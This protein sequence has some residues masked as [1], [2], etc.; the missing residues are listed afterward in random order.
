MVTAVLVFGD[1]HHPVRATVSLIFV[2]FVPGLAILRLIGLRDLEMTILL[3]IPLSLSLDAAMSAVLV[4]AGLSAWNLGLSILLSVTVGAV[5]LDVARPRVAAVRSPR[6]V[7][8]KLEDEVRQ[9]EVVRALLDGGSLADAA[10][11]ARVDVTTLQRAIRRSPAFRSAVAVAS[12]SMVDGDDVR[13]KR[14]RTLPASD[15]R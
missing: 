4:Y 13:A 11:A 6:H 1:V 3:A 2:A 9:A 15:R 14:G 8:G 10:E 12:R 5:I 7:G